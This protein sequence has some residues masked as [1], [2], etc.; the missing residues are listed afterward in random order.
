MAIYPHVSHSEVDRNLKTRRIFVVPLRCTKGRTSDHLPGE[1][2][3]IWQALELR[4][5]FFWGD[6]TWANGGGVVSQ[7][8]NRWRSLFIWPPLYTILPSRAKICL[9]VLISVTTNPEIVYLLYTQMRS[10]S[11]YHIMCFSCTLVWRPGLWGWNSRVLIEYHYRSL[12]VFWSAQSSQ[13]VSFFPWMPPISLKCFAFINRVC[14][15]TRKILTF[16]GS[17]RGFSI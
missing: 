2:K 17:G 9:G 11:C 16:R 14:V 12:I 8:D 4:L 7:S 15:A 3:N 6:G 10:L 13:Q 5:L 1:D